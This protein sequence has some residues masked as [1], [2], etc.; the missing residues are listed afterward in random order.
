MNVDYSYFLFFLYEENNCAALIEVL[1]GN[2]GDELENYEVLLPVH[3]LRTIQNIKNGEKEHETEQI[4]C[5][6]EGFT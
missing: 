3:S 1:G 4:R 5:K 6:L 2:S